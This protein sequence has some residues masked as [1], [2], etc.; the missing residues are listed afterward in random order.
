MKKYCN[1][2]LPS[3]PSSKEKADE[4]SE[5][6]RKTEGRRGEQ[7]RKEELEEET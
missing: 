1:R 7:L 6:E 2:L 5:S 3:F 4:Q